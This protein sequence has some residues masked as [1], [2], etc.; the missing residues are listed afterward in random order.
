MVMDYLTYR[1]QL[2]NSELYFCRRNLD[3]SRTNFEKET[4]NRVSAV[5]LNSLGLLVCCINAVAFGDYNFFHIGRVPIS[6][7]LT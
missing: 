5:D 3:Y 4:E 2:K 7:K 1:S 6:L